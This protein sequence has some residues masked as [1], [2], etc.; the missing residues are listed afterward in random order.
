MLLNKLSYLSSHRSVR[1]AVLNV[2]LTSRRNMS[3]AQVEFGEQLDQP[4]PQHLQERSRDAW[5][6]QVLACRSEQRK[7]GMLDAVSK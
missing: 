1:A 3:C 7:H 5:N 2:N 4:E 6:L